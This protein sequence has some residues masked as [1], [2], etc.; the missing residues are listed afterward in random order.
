MVSSWR[1]TGGVSGVTGLHRPGTARRVC[2]ALCAVA[3][4]SLTLVA[5]PPAG[6]SSGV[7]MRMIPSRVH[8]RR[9]HLL[10]RDLRSGA[11]RARTA[12]VG[13]TQISITQAPWQVFVVAFLSETDELLCGGSILDETEVLT[14]GHC[15][16][17]P[18]TRTRIPAEQI[19]VVA[20]TSDLEIFEAEEQFSFASSVRVHPY[21]TYDPESTSAVPDD[22]AVL[23]LEIPLAFTPSTKSIGPTPTGALPA[24]GAAVKLT[25]FGEE[26]PLL[27]E[28]NG[29]LY[30]LGMTLGFSHQCGGE[31]DAVFL[32][33]SAPGG[34]LCFGDSGSALTVPGSPGTVAGVADTVQAIS[35]KPCLDGAI[36][37]FANVSAP[38]I[39]DFIKGS[40]AP[41]RA[42]RGGS[43]TVIRGL[44]VAGQSLR[45]ESGSWSNGP[46]LTYEFINSATGQVLQQGSSSTYALSAADVGR[47][48]FCQVQAAN[49]GGTGITR[50]VAL[51][52]IQPAPPPPP[53]PP[54]SGGASPGTGGSPGGGA[55][56]GNPQGGVLGS[57]G[58]NI[59]SGQIASLLVQQLTPAGRGAKIAALRRSGGFTVTFKALEAGTAVIAWYQDPSGATVANKT[60]PKPVL[61]ASGRKTFSAAGT[62]KLKI[63]LTAAGKRLLKSAKSLKLTAKGTFTPSG[64]TPV[65]ASKTFV[66]KQ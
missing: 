49:A 20:G 10:V 33:A 31:A 29:K 16:F 55:G 35:G 9:G 26:D 18:S 25:G 32:C 8:L 43:G 38:E 62:A 53:P 22:V 2:G 41:P 65:T 52:P 54:G 45:C 1:L 4:V 12:I 3:I 39:E 58:T 56:A 23:H 36:G 57:T 11:R 48:I 47:T 6:A 61:V 63:D 64:S 44:I 37:G 66:L 14:A 46:T 21:F 30:S 42:P 34:S 15:V 27:S 59:S 5:T 40:E 28:L 50:T 17:N 7:P 24:E 19:V 13:G 51:P 60:K